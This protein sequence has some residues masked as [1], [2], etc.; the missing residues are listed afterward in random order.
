MHLRE[1]VVNNAPCW[2]LQTYDLEIIYMRVLPGI[3]MR[4]NS[5][6]T[7][8]EYIYTLGSYWLIKFMEKIV[9]VITHTQQ[10]FL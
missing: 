9:M 2:S 4:H 1:W 8:R 5:I 7:S 3:I 10:Y 6:D